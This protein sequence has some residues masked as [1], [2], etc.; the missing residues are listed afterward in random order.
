LIGGLL[1]KL[2]GWLPTVGVEMRVFFVMMTVFYLAVLL[3]GV[4]YIRVFT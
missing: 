1:Q 2:V 3:F 4:A